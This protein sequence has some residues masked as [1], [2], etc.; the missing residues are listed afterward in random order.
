MQNISQSMMIK[1]AQCPSPAFQLFRPGHQLLRTCSQPRTTTQDKVSGQKHCYKPVRNKSGFSARD[2]VQ[3]GD[4][5]LSTHSAA[6][7]GCSCR[8]SRS[9]DLDWAPQ[10]AGNEPGPLSARSQTMIDENA[11]W[12]CALLTLLVEERGAICK[13]FSNYAGQAC[14]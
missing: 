8:A 3:W 11:L 13:S 9:S 4:V 10:M 7:T 12:D 2:A 5:Y 1:Q 6:C 14:A